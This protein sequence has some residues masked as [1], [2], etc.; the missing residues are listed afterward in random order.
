VA[1]NPTIVRSLVEFTFRNSPEIPN[2]CVDG[3]SG[4]DE[5]HSND[6]STVHTMSTFCN[7]EG[8]RSECF[9][10][11]NFDSHLTIIL[12]RERSVV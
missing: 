5:T 3:R 7:L 8:L 4:K 10:V 12:P 2:N 9:E 6:G 11:V 1:T